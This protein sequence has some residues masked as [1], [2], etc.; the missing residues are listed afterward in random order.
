MSAAG[1]I[2]WPAI[3]CRP[4]RSR[5]D[6]WPPYPPRH[7]IQG[8]HSDSCP[9]SW[10]PYPPRHWASRGCTPTAA[11]AVP[12]CSFEAG[13]WSDW[14]PGKAAWRDCFPGKHARHNRPAA[15]R[16]S[17]RQRQPFGRLRSCWLLAPSLF[18]CQVCLI[19]QL[20]LH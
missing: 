12:L 4:G 9:P 19:G 1:R 17:C 2:L 6:S 15:A 13:C 20:C 16:L 3:F 7:C 11:H 8:L 5:P 10:P 14:A 18:C